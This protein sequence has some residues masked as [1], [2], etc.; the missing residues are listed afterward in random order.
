[1][2][3]TDRFA[4]RLVLFLASALIAGHANK[5]G[6]DAHRIDQREKPDKKLEIG[7]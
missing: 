3:A 5:D 4:V 7:W 2:I 1:M 6:N